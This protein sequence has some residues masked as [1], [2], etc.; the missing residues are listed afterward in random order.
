MSD[1]LAYWR[2]DNY[3]RDLA[4]GAGFHFN[5]NQKRLHV[6]LNEGDSLWVVTGRNEPRRAGLAYHIVARLVIRAK[7]LNDP[8]Y[9]Y[10]KYRV[11]GDLNASK[12][13]LI[14]EHEASQ[15]IRQLQFTTGIA[16]GN[17][18]AEISQHL[19][20][21]R[22]LNV[23]DI[24]LLNQWCSDLPLE[25]AAYSILP[26]EDLESA[27]EQ[28][29]DAVKK[30]IREHRS[31]IAEYRISHLI[32][33]PTRS[34]TLAREIHQTYNGRCQICG[35]DPVLIYNVEACHAH[36][37]VYLSRGGEDKL[38]NMVLLCPNHHSVIHATDAVFDFSDLSFVFAPNHRERLALNHHLQLNN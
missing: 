18:P 6:V 30:L 29:S 22:E 38:S 25:A 10:G 34:R 19:Q 2:Y 12:Y 4:E 37:L 31:G 24:A 21:M 36:H 20:T 28:N 9:K 11:W 14:G 15:L 27:V 32:Q 16:I 23:Q 1:V 17:S 3:V 26:E 33:Q 8:N 13:Y 7:T 5:S 35:F